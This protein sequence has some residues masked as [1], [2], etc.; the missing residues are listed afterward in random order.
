M[1]I[2][3]QHQDPIPHITMARIKKGADISTISTTAFSLTNK[4][5]VD[6]MELWKTVQTTEG[7]IYQ[8]IDT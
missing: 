3:P 5:L 4:M 1:T 7:V 8:R 6:K 2:I